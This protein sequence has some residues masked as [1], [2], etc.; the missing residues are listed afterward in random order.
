METLV[1]QEFDEIEIELNPD[2]VR[3]ENTFSRIKIPLTAS[4]FW[5]IR[6]FF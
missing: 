5:N 1:K 4:K 3:P 2:E 6:D